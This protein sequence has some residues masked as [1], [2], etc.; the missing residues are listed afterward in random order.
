V[1]FVLVPEIEIDTAKWTW[2]EKYAPTAEVTTDDGSHTVN[3]RLTL[4]DEDRFTEAFELAVH[5]SNVCGSRD[6]LIRVKPV[7]SIPQFPADSLRV[8]HYCPDDSAYAYAGIPEDFVEKGVEYIWTPVGTIVYL[9]DSVVRK[10]DD[11]AEVET[12]AWMRFAASASG[13]DT[14]IIHFYAQ[15][16]CNA[17]DTVTVRTAP[18]TYAIWAKAGKD[19]VVYGQSGVSLAVD[20]TQYGSP[21]DYTYVWQP[22]DRVTVDDPATPDEPWTTFA[23]KGLYNPK[24]YFRVI[25]TERIDMNRPF[26]FGRSACKAFDTVEIFV[27]STF[28]MEVAATD[29]ACMDALFEISAK[30]YGGNSERYY[31][32]WYRLEGDSVYTPVADDDHS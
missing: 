5:T 20:S 17:T 10:N 23:T 2:P 18:Y 12:V 21:V 9:Q 28:A 4:K 27:D 26:Y 30:P 6:T 15:N 31:F 24:E 13:A 25:A 8:S 29:T 7:D 22:E 19:T 16:D 1:E 3:N 14:S 32:D 11:P